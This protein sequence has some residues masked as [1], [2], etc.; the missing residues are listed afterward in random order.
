MAA[1]HPD[2]KHVLSLGAALVFATALVA[3]A[4]V[5]TDWNQIAIRTTEIAGAPV[6]AQTRS[7]AMVHAAIFDAVN[8]LER[9][10]TVYAVKL[11]PMPGASPEVAAAVAAHGVLIQLYPQQKALLDAALAASLTRIPE[12]P[13]RTDGVKAGQEVAAQLVA[14]RRNDG[15]ATT[16]SYTFGTG[17][18]VY[19]P[20]PPMNAS[21][22]LPHWRNVKPFAVNGPK[23]FPISGPPAPESPAFARDFNEVKRLGAG[24]SAERTTEQTAIAIHW[25]GSEVPP[26]NAVA[27]AA[28]AAKGLSLV[29]SARLFALLNIAMADSLI[30]GFDAKYVF[31]YWRPI[32]AIRNA[33]LAKNAAI[34]AESDWGPLLVTPPHPEYPSAHCLGAGAAVAILQ[35]VFEGD[36]LA[37]S[38]IYPPL[39]VLRRWESFSQI[40]K[41]VE[42]ARVWAGIHYRTSVEHGTQIGRQVAEFILKT[43]MRPRPN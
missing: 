10:Y 9:K 23:Q 27:R 30:V 12:G 43:Q 33:G 16:Q 7:M 1:M 34:A 31:N 24:T 37:T 25:A 42:D 18:G 13:A 28:A 38:Y 2:P 29:D 22:I 26:L 20:T 36:K 41:E 40:E 39:G 15:A 19:Q 6:P 8:G 21:P 35:H 17:A 4:D 3:R 32:T 14:L 11:G 5:V